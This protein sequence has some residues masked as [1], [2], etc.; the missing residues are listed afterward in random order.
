MPP[1][2]FPLIAN[3]S[4]GCAGDCKDEAPTDNTSLVRGERP[5]IQRRKKICLI[6]NRNDFCSGKNLLK[7]HL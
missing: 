5:V 1:A 7:F 3:T 2:K 4:Q 6:N